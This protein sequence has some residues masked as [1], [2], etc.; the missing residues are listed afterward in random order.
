MQE[1]ALYQSQ[2]YPDWEKTRG[3]RI[4]GKVTVKHTGYLITSIPYDQGF[5]IKSDG[6]SIPVQKVNTAFLGAAVSEGEHQIEIEYH[7]PGVKMGK[8]VSV[9]GAVLWAGMLLGQCNKKAHMLENN[10]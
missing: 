5:T 8:L 9:I 2:F 6:N 4:S 1:D 7:A 3:N 10:R